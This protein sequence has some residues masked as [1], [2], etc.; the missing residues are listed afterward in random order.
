MGRAYALPK[1]FESADGRRLEM[2]EAMNEKIEL[3]KLAAAV[4][5]IFETRSEQIFGFLYT[6]SYLYAILTHRA[7]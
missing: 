6:F 7:G 2:D 5:C 3:V 4:S 1:L